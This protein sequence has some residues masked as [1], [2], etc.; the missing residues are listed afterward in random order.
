MF[1]ENTSGL[2]FKMYCRFEKKKKN[3]MPQP[4]Y[5]MQK[6][7]IKTSKAPIVKTIMQ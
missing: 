4:M 1:K 6:I 7:R 2:H 3:V 5:Q